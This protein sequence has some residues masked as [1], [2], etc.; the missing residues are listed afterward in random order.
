MRYRVYLWIDDYK[1]F[2]KSI[3]EFVDE[4]EDRIREIV[5]M[6][7]GG[8]DIY[9]YRMRDKYSYLENI[10]IPHYSSGSK[11]FSIVTEV[12]HDK[13]ANLVDSFSE[14]H[15]S[16]SEKEQDHSERGFVFTISKVLK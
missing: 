13:F 1:T 5:D 2:F 3:E 16:V 4:L 9:L 10:C 8:E 14:F 12:E 15:R 11:S 6:M 7:L